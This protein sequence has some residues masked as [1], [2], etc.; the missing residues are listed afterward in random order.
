MFAA[1]SYTRFFHLFEKTFSYGE[2]KLTALGLVIYLQNGQSIVQTLVMS[3][4]ACLDLGGEIASTATCSGL[5]E[6]DPLHGMSGKHRRTLG[7]M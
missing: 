2:S 5:Q 6:R 7:L 1:G 3:L 4:G